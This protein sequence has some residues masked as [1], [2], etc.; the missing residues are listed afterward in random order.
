MRKIIGIFLVFCL[1]FSLAGCGINKNEEKNKNTSNSEMT[2][3]KAMKK[4]AKIL[5]KMTLEEKIG[6]MILVDIDYLSQDEKD[7][8]EVSE[9]LLEAIETYKIGGVVLGNQNIENKEQI[10]TLIQEIS[11][12]V[13]KNDELKVP[14]YYGTQEQGGGTKSIAAN[15]KDIKATGYTS[16]A[17][18]GAN[19]T[20]GQ[21]EDTGEL[22]AGELLELGFNLNLAPSAD[23]R[24]S[25]KVINVA[26]VES[27][28]LENNLE[29]LGERPEYKPSA[30]KVSKKKEKKR[31]AAY[32]K[33]L[34]NYEDKCRLFIEKYR[35]DNYGE[36]CFGEEADKVSEAVV[37]MV[38]GM[39]AVSSDEGQSVSTVLT[40]FPG[41]SSVARY[42]KL[43]MVDVDKAL[44]TLRKENLKPFAEG[45]DAGTDFVMVGHVALTKI[46]GKTP[47]S[48]S[49]IIISKL[50]R[51]EM[52]F[53]GVV[54][55]EEMNLP[56]IVSEY[57][58]EQAVVKAVVSGADVIYN[59]KDI[60]EAVFALKRAVMFGEIEE[61]VVDQA[62]LRILQNKILRNVYPMSD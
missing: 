16:P 26:E 32:E 56:V 53:E 3:D 31:L 14:L 55:T 44:S 42:H 22:I 17:E 46:D 59:P 45:I 48:L 60:D 40:T 58:T 19:M 30:K 11:N 47:A 62:V 8:T 18:M 50:L 23:I 51:E 25:E 15:N 13:E 1:C 33:K 49:K 35:E 54:V 28:A 7:V 39:H 38:K 12:Y 61:K 2:A 37:A 5:K 43:T 29:I 4:A 9:E 27:I 41:I 57:T 10:Q 34:Q 20:E 24:Q 36:S 6:Q 21:L 52:G